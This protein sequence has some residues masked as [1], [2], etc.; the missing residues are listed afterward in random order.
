MSR[1]EAPDSLAA[2]AGVLLEHVSDEHLHNAVAVGVR[3]LSLSLIL[4]TWSS[5]CLRGCCDI[6]Q[7]MLQEQWQSA[8]EELWQ[9]ALMH[10]NGW[11]S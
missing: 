3:A 8:A 1:R 6:R 7:C 2:H 5:H 4:L 9:F 11:R 10:A